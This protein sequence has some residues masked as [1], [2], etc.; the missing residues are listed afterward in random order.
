MKHSAPAVIMAIGIFL[1][2]QLVAMVINAPYILPTPLQI[3]EK[4]WVLKENLFF[5][6]LPATL[7]VTGIGLGISI[8]LGLALAMAMDRFP[9]L[10][11]ALYPVV[12]ATQTIPTTAIAPL[13]VLWFGYSIWSKVLVTILITFFPITITVFDGLKSTKREMEELLTSYGASPWDIFWKLKLPTALPSFFSAIKMAIPLSVIG[14][15]IAEWLG[16]Q[17]G[18]GYF[19]KRMMTQLDGAGV[20]APIDLLSVVAMVAVFIITKIEDHWITWRKDA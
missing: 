7:Q 9:A 10:E 19:S 2:W 5:V 6:Q 4:I 1:V 12:V 11:R 17:E 13:F 16:A 3:L 14:A 20:Y 18:L 8:V 15:A